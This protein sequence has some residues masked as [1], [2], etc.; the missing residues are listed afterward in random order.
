MLSCSI[1][2]T[3]MLDEKMEKLKEFVE[4]STDEMMNLLLVSLISSDN[5]MCADDCKKSLEFSKVLRVA[6]KHADIPDEKKQIYLEYIAKGENIL[7]QDLEHFK[8]ETD[9]QQE[10]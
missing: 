8:Q 1:K 3:D 2:I 4:T 6:V 7:N 9:K 5:I 10:Q